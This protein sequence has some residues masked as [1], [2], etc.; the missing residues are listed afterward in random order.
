[1]KASAVYEGHY[2]LGT[3]VARPVIAKKQIEI[4]K[5][6][7]ADA[8]AHGATGK[9]NDQ[10]RFELAYYGLNPEIKVIAPWRT[11]PFKSRTDLLHYA[12]EHGIPVTATHSKPYSTDGNL[13]HISYEG[14]ILEDP[15]A[16]PQ[17]I[18]S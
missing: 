17:K 1:M 13:M 10:V 5:Q 7:G 4:A 18:F 11:W 14:G 8:V 3:S 16:A 12:A 15:W 9:G 2:L 6:V